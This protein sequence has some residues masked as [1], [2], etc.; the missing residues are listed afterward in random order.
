MMEMFT[1][2]HHVNTI[3][4]KKEETQRILKCITHFLN[5]FIFIEINHLLPIAIV[6]KSIAVLN[7]LY[8]PKFASKI[9]SVQDH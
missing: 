5:A 6:Q 2:N 1:F 4:K 9:P 7:Y 3:K 8:W